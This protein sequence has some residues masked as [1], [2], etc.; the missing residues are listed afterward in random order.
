MRVALFA[1]CF[2]EVNG[3]SLTCGELI[4]YAR[5]N[6]RPMLAV[7]AGPCSGMTSA[8][9]VTT[10]QLARGALRLPVDADFDYDVLFLRHWEEARR[11]V[12]QF[13]PNVVHITGP[14]DCGTLGALLA[15]R[16]RIPIVASWHTNVHEFAA[17]R[18]ARVLPVTGAVRSV[19]SGIL[20]ILLRFYRIA[21][22]ILAPNGELVDMLSTRTG[23]P[24]FLMPRGVD[25]EL[26]SPSRRE[27]RDGPFTFGYVGRIVAEKNLELLIDVARELEKRGSHEYRFLV[28]GQG[29]ETEWL[30][31]HLPKSEFPGVLRG[32]DLAR[33]Y[34][35]MDAFLFPSRTDTFGNVV[36]ESIASGVP[37]VVTD[38]GGPK[39]L[40]D[41][42]V[43]GFVTSTRAQFVDSALRLMNERWQVREPA[44]TKADSA[45]WDSVFSGVYRA[46]THAL[47]ST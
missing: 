27:R 25:R 3:V 22:V 42:G 10:L 26:F 4:K 7:H 31:K 12:E 5:R 28:V 39:Y 43:N 21:R 37:V 32:P 16:L 13:R 1:D 30:R 40:V 15:H 36:L 2:H 18:L 6:S 24:V 19:E 20:D 44:G 14:G 41:D 9:S 34:A 33:A 29:A 38:A 46:Y 23:R 45:S 35:A 17:R 11:A 8:G 47:A